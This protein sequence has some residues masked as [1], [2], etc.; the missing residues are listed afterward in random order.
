M[1]LIIILVYQLLSVNS[2]PGNITNSGSHYNVRACVIVQR[3]SEL[4]NPNYSFDLIQ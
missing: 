3:V 1:L 2:I 4:C